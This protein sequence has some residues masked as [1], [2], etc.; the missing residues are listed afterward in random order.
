[1]NDRY[2]V[3][4]GRLRIWFCLTLAGLLLTAPASS[5][6]FNLRVQTDLGGFASKLFEVGNGFEGLRGVLFMMGESLGDS[7]RGG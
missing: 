6:D 7:V 3:F 1:M 4:H 2:A 5:A